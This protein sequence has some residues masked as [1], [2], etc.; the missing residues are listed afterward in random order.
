MTLFKPIQKLKAFHPFLGPLWILAGVLGLTTAYPGEYLLLQPYF[1][2]A[3]VVL[4][5]YGLLVITVALHPD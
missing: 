3:A 2:T 4:I 5:A 1:Y